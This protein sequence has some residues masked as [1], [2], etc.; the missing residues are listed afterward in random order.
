[1][2]SWTKEAIFYHIYPLGFCGAPESNNIY[3][4]PDNRL[5]KVEEWIPHI[6]SIGCNALYLGPLFQ[7]S[8]HGYDTADYYHVDNRLGSDND[9]KELCNNLHN[10]G[11]RIIPDGVFNHVGREFWA[12][13]DVLEHGQASRYC[14]WFSNLRFDYRSPL[15]D[16]FTYD[17]WEGHYN[18]VKLNLKNPEVKEHLLGA[19]GSWIDD[20]GIDGLRLDAADCVDINF[21]KELSAYCKNKKNDFWLMG[22]IIHG[23]YRRWAN[24][25][26]L[27]S[28]TNYEC[29]KGLYSSHNDKNYFEIAYSLNR[30]FGDGGIYKDLGLYNFVDNHDVNRL[31]STVKNPAHLYP[32]NVMLFT[33]PGIP[34]IY[35]GSEWGI[36]GKKQNNSDAPLRPSLDLNSIPNNSPNKDIINTITKLSKIKKESAALK[37]GSYKQLTVKNEQF[38]YSRISN[39]ETIII[40]LNLSETES[41]IEFD[42]PTH[43]NCLVDVLNNDEHFNVN[44]S[45]ISLSVPSCWARILKVC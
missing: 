6:K 19:V 31:A 34:S 38:V 35:Y 24:A 45:R 10:N 20:F 11:I 14:S 40:A 39:N 4:Q 43:G 22:E 3:A 41:N 44:S 7:S 25:E 33:M 8:T 32:I 30:Q 37:Y 15:G 5:K 12:F 13:R 18:L 28:V 27:D 17:C 16:N 29:Y 1:M 42:M 23:D 21:L 9:F 36:L 2:N 26:T